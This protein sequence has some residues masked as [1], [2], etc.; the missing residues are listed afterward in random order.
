MAACNRKRYRDDVD[1]CENKKSK[2]RSTYTSDMYH[3]EKKQKTAKEHA[4]LNEVCQAKKKYDEKKYATD[5]TYKQKHKEASKR[6]YNPNEFIY[7]KI[8]V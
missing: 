4:A 2:Q 7:V 1:Y 5:L 3:R 6:K 8:I